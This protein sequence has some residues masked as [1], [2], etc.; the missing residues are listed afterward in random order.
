MV[1]NWIFKTMCEVIE[2]NLDYKI[3]KRQNK[4]LKKI[5]DKHTK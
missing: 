3:T 1:N 4:I 2:S 5:I